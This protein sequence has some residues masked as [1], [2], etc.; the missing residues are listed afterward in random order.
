M[1]NSLAT[2]RQQAGR[3]LG[4]GDTAMFMGTPTGG[5]AT[6]G[7]QCSAFDQYENDFFNDW[8]IRVYS[9]THKN[10]SRTVTDFVKTNGVITFS[11]AVVASIDA[12]DLFELHRDFSPEEI[13][14]AINMAIMM[15]E[16][17]AL[18][19]RVDETLEIVADT[20]RYNLPGGFYTVD[21]IYQESS[22]A[23]TYHPADKF[24]GRSWQILGAVTET[25]LVDGV[26]WQI[27]VDG[28]TKTIWFD[29][30]L[31][32]LTGG[33]GLRV[34]GQAKASQLTLDADTTDIHPAYLVQQAVALLHLSRITDT[35]GVSE[36]HTLQMKLSQAM[37]DRE[38]LKTFVMPRGTRV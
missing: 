27:S 31:A 36:K 33:R 7:F 4:A 8:W 3:L 24:D 20:Y 17:E 35:S 29:K 38:R 18:A 30:N 26:E 16:T 9:G 22:T 5:Y 10:T 23:D 12:T 19:N 34:E 32:T 13:N 2:L 28:S 21:S 6:T 25:L 14:A 15:V 1:S 37:A 11:P